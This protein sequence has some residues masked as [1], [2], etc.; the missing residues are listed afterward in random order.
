MNIQP[1]M[2]SVALGERRLSDLIVD[3]AP[4]K[5]AHDLGDL[6]AGLSKAV[7]RTVHADACLV[8]L[9]TDDGARLRD[10]GAYVVPPAQLN[11]V[12][13]EYLLE[14]FPLTQAVLESRGHAEIS[15]GDPDCDESERRLLSVLGFARSLMCEFSIEDEVTGTVEVYRL[16]DRPFRDD[17]HEQV[18]L[19]AAFAGSSYSKILYAAK[20][21]DHYTE[22]IGALTS[23]LE[24]RDSYTEAHAGRIRE[25]SVSLATALKVSNETR[26]AVHL[27][28]LLH[29]VGKIGI[30]D[31]ILRKPGP[32][33]DEEWSIMRQHPLIGE[34]MLRN[35]DFLAPALP[36]VRHHHE[37]W[38]GG[39][40][41]DG[42]RQEEIPLPARIVAVCDAYD[43]MTSDRPYRKAMTV[44]QAIEE[45]ERHRGRQFDP[46]CVDLFTKLVRELG[47]AHDRRLVR[48]AT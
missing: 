8:S 11:I 43:A 40:Y 38:D 4:M 47:E 29:D 22:T 46:V 3:L 35:V 45:L 1:E 31:T 24:A 33:A 34:R 12:V 32:L 23:A 41:P 28:S 36:V 14:N 16:E 42:L 39:G 37:A 48:Y 20:L 5:E 9:V 19:L 25:L 26:Y 18:E 27:G 44:D 15:V 6:F 2:E 10:V 30:P 7:A 13:E 21:E 17:D